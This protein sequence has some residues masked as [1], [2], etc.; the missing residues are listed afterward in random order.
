MVVVVV[1]VWVAPEDESVA[2]STEV[3]EGRGAKDQVVVRRG[4]EQGEDPG[5]GHEDLH[6]RVPGGGAKVCS[7][8][9]DRRKWVWWGVRVDVGVCL[10]VF[11]CVC[12]YMTKALMTW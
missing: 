8:V 4:E 6:G 11:V 12:G 5:R 9:R 3:E 10:C 2:E 7:A 1:V